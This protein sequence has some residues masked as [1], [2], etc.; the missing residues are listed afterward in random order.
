MTARRDEAPA[1]ASPAKPA[2]QLSER[3]TNNKHGFEVA[4]PAGWHTNDD[5]VIPACSV[6][7]PNPVQIPRQSELPF[8]IAISIGVHETKAEE[9]TT[10]TQWERVLST[11]PVAIAGRQGFRVEV[12][13]TGEGLAERGMRTTRYVVDLGGPRTLVAATH[14]ANRDYAH[15]SEILRAMVETLAAR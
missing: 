8:E 9:L 13:A 2:A 15:N 14:S 6:F 3:C 10:T 7:D 12:E 11:A 5:S 4:Y 1:P